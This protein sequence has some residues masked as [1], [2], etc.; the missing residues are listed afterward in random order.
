MCSRY[1]IDVE[2]ETIVEQL[3]LDGEPGDFHPGE[4]RPTNTAPVLFS[5]N[6]TAL[7]WGIPAPWDGKPLINAR[8]ET[9]EE[10]ATFSPLLE[11]RCLIPASAYFE[12][13]KDGKARLKNRISLIDGNLMGFAGLCTPKSRHSPPTS[14][15]IA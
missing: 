13:R 2:W 12:W 5:G 3:G 10:K 1:E 6:L 15:A 14:N 8:S 9:L 4:I 7:R 11:H